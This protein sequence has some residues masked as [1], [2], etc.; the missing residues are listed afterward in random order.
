[1]TSF[2][3]GQAT[4]TI[5][6][7]PDILYVL[8][9]G[10]EHAKPATTTPTSPIFVFGKRV[11]NYLLLPRQISSNVEG[12]RL[13]A[14]MRTDRRV[15][16]EDILDRINP[17]FGI[18]VEDLNARRAEFLDEFHL[19]DWDSDECG[20]IK[21]KLTAAGI[22]PSLNST[23]GLT[24]GLIDPARGEAGDRIP[25]PPGFRYV[26]VP[27]GNRTPHPDDHHYPVPLPGDID[28]G[29]FSSPLPVHELQPTGNIDM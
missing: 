28:V 13:E 7:L 1:M 8:E 26:L 12:W 17:K 14:W 20:T 16:A 2:H 5:D 9:P 24:P 11:K 23:R 10:P 6:N 3:S 15:T 22:G 4:W 18:T 29:I 25:I 19:V 27:R 21:S